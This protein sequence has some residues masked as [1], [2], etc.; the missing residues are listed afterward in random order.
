MSPATPAPAPA[1]AVAATTPTAPAPTP[2]KV[3]NLTDY[4]QLEAEENRIKASSG[5]QKREPELKVTV[6]D[7]GY[8]SILAYVVAAAWIGLMG[9]TTNI[10]LFYVFEMTALN[11]TMGSL[12]VAII[13]IFLTYDKFYI[14]VE[15]QTAEVYTNIF[16]GNLFAFKYGLYLIPPWFIYQETVNFRKDEVKLC[17]LYNK[18]DKDNT[19]LKITS[20]DPYRLDVEWELIARPMSDA[21]GL[22]NYLQYQSK[23]RESRIRSIMDSRISTIGGYY[24]YKVLRE[25]FGEMTQWVNGIFGGD[26]VTTSFELEIGMNITSPRLKNILCNDPEAEKVINKT[27]ELQQLSDF[28]KAHPELGAVEAKDA[29]LLIMGK[30][31]SATQTVVVQGIPPGAKTVIIGGNPAFTAGK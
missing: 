27:P 7:T 19:A 23:I 14:D 26:K 20:S 12:I 24:T 10:I 2:V 1:P 6:I 9:I 17:A 15:A 31:T 8:G 3:L 16:E 29:A 22:A 30:K 28:I 11:A 18:E 5:T 13:G 21:V 4:D 25:N